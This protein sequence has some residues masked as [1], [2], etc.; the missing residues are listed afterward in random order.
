MAGA[1]PGVCAARQR[2]G[3][4][5]I[6]ELLGRESGI[7]GD[8]RACFP[9]GDA[10]KLFNVAATGS[11]PA[12]ASTPRPLPAARTEVPHPLSTRAWRGCAMP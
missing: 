4:T 10:E 6:L 8:I 9:E 11:S 2:T 7:D 1:E 3:L 5:G 12:T